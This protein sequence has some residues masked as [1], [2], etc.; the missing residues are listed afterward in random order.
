MSISESAPLVRRIDHT[1]VFVSDLQRSIVWYE[2]VL[3]LTCAY[4]GDT[5]NNIPGAFFDVGD[6]ILAMLLTADPE[7]NLAEQ[8]FAFA[9]ESADATHA[10]LVARG[11]VPLG[12]P[13]NLPRGYI[14]GQRSFEI[15]DPDGVRIEFVQRANIAVNLNTLHPAGSGR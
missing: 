1:A 11:H 4:H 7:R 5:G 15:L 13:E 9:V 3:G 6:T 8:H 2:Q 10:D 12:A 14:Q